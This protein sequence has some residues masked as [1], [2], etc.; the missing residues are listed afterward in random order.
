MSKEVELDVVHLIDEAFRCSWQELDLSKT[1]MTDLPS[2]IG[3]LASLKVLTLGIWHRDQTERVAYSSGTLPTEIGN[4][5]NLE[6]LSLCGTN[7][8]ELPES[9]GK[10][11]NLERLNLDG[12]DLVKLP[13]SIGQLTRLKSLSLWDTSLDELPE[14]IG[15]LANNLKHLNLDSTDLVKLP[16]SIGQLTH[17]KSLS[18]RNTNL[19]ELPKGIGQLVSLESLSLRDTNL[20]ELPESIGQLAC[21]SSLDLR[22]TAISELP[23]S[24]GQLT[25]LTDLGLRDTNL[26]ELPES[27]GQLA[28]LSSLDLRGTAVSKLPESMYQLTNL[29]RLNLRGTNL[30]TLPENIGQ[31]QSLMRL[32][33]AST[34]ICQLPES[35]EQLI[36]LKSLSLN[37]TRLSVFPECIT[38]LISLKGLDLSGVRIEELPASIGQLINLRVLCMN[39]VRIEELPAS[40]GQL[41]NLKGLFLS[42]TRLSRFPEC[43][44]RLEKLENLYLR[45]TDVSDI[46][47]SIGQLS[48]LKKL[49]LR[50]THLSNLP[51]SVSQLNSL[52]F[53]DLY[54]THISKLPRSIG[55]L[56]NLRRLDISA[57]SI[58]ELPKS[59]G[60]LSNLRRLDARNTKLS[61]LPESVKP[62]EKLDRLCLSSCRL[63]HLPAWCLTW[64]APM[65]LDLRGNPLP[66]PEALLGS[67]QEWKEPGDFKAVLKFYF[68]GQ[69]PEAK[70]LYEA[71]LL[72]VGEG[73][74]GKTTLSKKLLDPQYELKPLESIS[75]EKSTEGIDILQWQ[76]EHLDGNVF[77]V[78]IWDFGGQEL[79][80]AT[81]QFFLTTRSLYILV[82]DSR[83]ENPNFY[84]WLN[85]VRLCSNNSPV[86]IVRNEKQDRRCEI[87][88]GLLRAEF[89]NLLCDQVRV[90]F[91]DNR[92]LSSLETVIKKHIV[93]LEGV[94]KPWPPSWMGV[95][96]AL[97]NY[98]LNYITIGEYTRLCHVNG[99]SDKQEALYLSGLLHELGICLHFQREVGLKDYI[100]LNPSWVTNAIYKVADYPKVQNDLGRFTREDLD[101][102]WSAR[103]YADMREELLALM[104]MGNFGICYPLR[105]RPDTYIIPSLL[106][107]VR[108]TY[109]WDSNQNLTIRYRYEFMPKG[110]VVRLIVEMHEFIE[111]DPSIT[112]V[113]WKM[114]AVFRYKD[115]R[116]EVIENYNRREL[117]IR[118]VGVQRKTLLDW[119]RR[120]IYKIHAT[121]PNLDCEE[122][123]P[124]NCDACRGSEN[125]ETYAYE[126]LIERID[127]VKYE[128]ECPRKP[129]QMVDVRQLVSDIT[130]NHIE[131]IEEE[132]LSLPG[133]ERPETD[134]NVNNFYFNQERPR[135]MSQFTQN[136]YGGSNF[137]NENRGSNIYQGTNYINHHA[138]PKTVAEAAKEIQELLV[139]LSKDNPL[140]DTEDRAEYLR[141]TLPKTRL[142]RSSELILTAAEA[143]IEE[144]PF[145]K[146]VTA[147]LKKIKE[148][149]MEKKQDASHS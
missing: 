93:A 131:N 136:N 11:A 50:G 66:I 35:I 53:L 22:G 128:I 114:G 106:S 68:Q 55:Q 3:C 124:C 16:E 103:Q 121:Y 125:P 89:K 72:I 143:A 46:P 71:K 20:G 13:E 102:I 110:T 142:Q 9:I 4:L 47:E 23:E 126:K 145:G 134:R 76:F 28:C 79:Y 10:L 41:I 99:I 30:E 91:A 82:V 33:L 115:A 45:G 119:I 61:E 96:N 117:L 77:R 25:R 90:N 27:I 60:Q 78:N 148:Q 146:V 101:E 29:L 7:L 133:K 83:R 18:L 132:T 5:E 34:H 104:Q 86:F 113:V 137:Q 6:V 15:Q 74:T 94:D 73:E 1:S 19:N 24:I 120:E 56:S 98:S 49:S 129:Y 69:R 141:K 57:T 43:I 139:Q 92:G 144:V 36:N 2:E 44:T 111:L 8:N 17:L 149:E 37:G 118:V 95:R 97:E 67:K 80:H 123:I 135:N 58:S 26:G 88:E 14:S 42:G 75:S 65:L 62:L 85:V 48:R 39:G 12:T 116:A 127:N 32:N 109:S 59:I 84:Y 100:I 112:G 147:V 64:K 21:L 138:E 107:A 70:P 52:T 63:S 81:H 87:D 51:E 122:L 105:D 40:I 54:R 38:R 140:A 31:I 130:T 108:P